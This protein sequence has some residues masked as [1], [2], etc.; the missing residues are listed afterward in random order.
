MHHRLKKPRRHRWLQSELQLLWDRVIRGTYLDTIP[1]IFATQ[2]VARQIAWDIFDDPAEG[3][4][5]QPRDV[6]RK[7][8]EW[9]W[10][11]VASAH[12]AAQE[13]AAWQVCNNPADQYCRGCKTKTRPEDLLMCDHVDQHT[14]K[15]CDEGWHLHCLNPVLPVVPTGAWYCYNHRATHQST[16]M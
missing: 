13:E 12:P 4:G 11:A 2:S 14:H 8:A 1:T 7:L 3:S 6:E 5:P 15:R 9:G 16:S 10:W